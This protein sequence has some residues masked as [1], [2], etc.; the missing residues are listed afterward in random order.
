MRD[1][2]PTAF[3][4][5]NDQTAI[6]VMIGLKTRG[7]DIPEDFSVTGFD[8]VPQAVFMTPS[9]TTIRQP[10]TAIGKHAMALLLELLSDGEPP[11]TEIL[12]RPDLVVR[13]SVSAPSRTRR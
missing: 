6:G 3:M 9:L 13:N 10:R 5:V 11:E 4:C 2:L 12:L 8:D 1:T 7:Y